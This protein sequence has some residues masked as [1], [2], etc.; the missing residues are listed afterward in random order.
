MLLRSGLTL[1]DAGIIQ[2]NAK[3]YRDLGLGP[4][5][6]PTSLTLRRL[7]NHLQSRCGL[8]FGAGVTMA[9][10]LNPKQS[11]HVSSIL[12]GDTMVPNIE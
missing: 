11:F 1:S 2:Q 12:F 9:P 10:T 7:A 8:I 4:C 3:H 6:T 5:H